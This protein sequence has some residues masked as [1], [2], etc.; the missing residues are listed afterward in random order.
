MK[1]IIVFLIINIL[2]YSNTV[3][4]GYR[5]S[6]RLPLINNEDNEGLYKDLYTEAFRRMGYELEIVRLPKVRVLLELEK[7]TIDFYPGFT[8]TNGRAKYIFYI[9]NG[10]Y[11]EDV[12]LTRA[13]LYNINSLEDLIGL[14]Y[15][16]PLGGPEYFD[17]E[18]I[19]NFIVA[20]Y[21]ELT[22]EQIINLLL[23]NRADFLLYDYDSLR[24][25]IN[26]NDIVGLKFH[27]EVLDRKKPMYLGFSQNSKYFKGEDN[28]E[29]DKNLPMS[30]DNFPI[31]LVEG[32]MLEE[33]K[34][35]LLEMK[36]DGFTDNLVKTYY[37]E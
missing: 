34:E 18:F 1:R 17:D 22:I 24:Y 31:K 35:T 7:G 16:R 23:Y 14:R 4:M 9:E 3:V 10:M 32:T 25:Y 19:E 21:P 36:Q 27:R 15:A 30:P 37:K 11:N 12:I 8:F 13:E 6:E 5:T 29:Y 33:L 20:E 28:E 2:I 26:K